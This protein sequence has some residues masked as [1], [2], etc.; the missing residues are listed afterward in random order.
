LEYKKTL[1]RGKMGGERKKN[2]R[3]KEPDE[4]GKTA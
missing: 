3:K 1:Y 2:R 4:I